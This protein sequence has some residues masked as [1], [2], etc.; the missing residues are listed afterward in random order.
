MSVIQ[1]L[2]DK[3]YIKHQIPEYVAVNSV[4]EVIMGSHAYGANLETS[5]SDLDIYCIYLPLREQ[6]F[7]NLSGRVW[8]FDEF[9]EQKTFQQTGIK[10][11]LESNEYDISCYPIT[12]FFKLASE[13][14]P[15]IVDSLF[16]EFE[17]IRKLTQNVGALIRENRKLF[18]SK[19]V[20]HKFRGYAY[21][22][23]SKIR[24]I[25]DKDGTL[26][27]FY[28]TVKEGKLTTKR[29]ELNLTGT[30]WKFVYHVVR[31]LLEC[32]QILEEG[33]LELKRHSDFLKYIR[34]GGMS[35]NDLLSWVSER[36]KSLE[37]IYN[38]SKLQAICEKEKI[39]E[40]LLN[41]LEAHY[42]SLDKVV[43]IPKQNTDNFVIELN[44]LMKKYELR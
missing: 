4:Y 3:G 29:E 20:Y 14:N 40:L 22:Q 13:S 9:P 32:T 24:T 36:E 42:G 8:G 16:V 41:C 39:R 43:Y 19:K 5:S 37:N 1:K 10:V 27:D 17:N 28:K 33:D 12:T 18:L 34:K 31:L 21:S 35:L 23:L 15:N 6:L 25:G 7:P 26:L 44:E 11:E 2:Y 30:D 38:N